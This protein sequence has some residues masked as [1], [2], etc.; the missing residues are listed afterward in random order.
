VSDEVN[1]PGAFNT[2]AGALAAALLIPQLLFG[3]DSSACVQLA[4]PLAAGWVMFD[5]STLTAVLIKL[6]SP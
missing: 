2:M 6:G 5:V 3:W 1:K 4:L